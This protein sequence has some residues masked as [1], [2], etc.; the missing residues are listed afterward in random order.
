MKPNTSIF[1]GIFILCILS[2]FFSWTHFFQLI[3][4]VN[5]D[6]ANPTVRKEIR[7]FTDQ[8]R[9]EFIDAVKQLNQGVR[10]SRYDLLS[11]LHQ[12]AREQ[13][14]NQPQFLPWH[15]AFLRE[16]EKALQSVN[17]NVVFPY[18]N[19]SVDHLNP[20]SSPVFSG[21]W[22]GGSGSCVSTGP[23]ANWQVTYKDYYSVAPHCLQRNLVNLKGNV[24]DPVTIQHIIF[25]NNG[26]EEFRRAI[27]GHPH[28][29]IHI[30]V[31]G[32]LNTLASPN[33]P[34]FYMHHAFVDKIWADWQKRD[35]QF[36][37][38]YG[39]TN[40]D[41][42]QAALTDYIQPFGVSVESVM[43]TTSDS[44]CY[45]YSDYPEVTMT[46]KGIDE[47]GSESKSKPPTPSSSILPTLKRL[48]DSWIEMTGGDVVK[49]RAEENRL[50][51]FIEQFNRNVT[52]NKPLNVAAKVH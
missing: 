6:C 8:E 16:F 31:G 18:W 51:K 36:V 11:R 15:R 48:P 4:F 39:G 35:P 44:M 10:P 26:F 29:G 40:K 43:S 1:R 33:D 47:D 42:S 38:Q 17:P 3:S 23:F 45:V 41:G 14:H 2:S 37:Y 7:Q 9:I 21:D 28:A 49:A 12:E 34:L 52:S 5:A 22:C 20:V 32:D 46:S 24:V 50:F 19:W 30:G 25:S 13:A 27:E